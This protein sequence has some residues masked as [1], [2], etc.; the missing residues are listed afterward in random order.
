MGRYVQEPLVLSPEDS[1]LK[2]L[3]RMGERGYARALVMEGDT[4]LGVLSKTDLLRAFQ[5]RLLG[6]TSL[7]RKEGQGRVWA[8]THAGGE[9]EASPYRP[10]TSGPGPEVR[11][12]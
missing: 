5:V 7:T 1:A 8:Q 3:E 10:R 11:G 6:L 2:A 12:R 4:L 9:H